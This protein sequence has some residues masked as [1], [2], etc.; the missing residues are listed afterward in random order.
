MKSLMLTGMFVGLFAMAA[1]AEP[2]GLDRFNARQTLQILENQ[3]NLLETNVDDI[4]NAERSFAKRRVDRVIQQLERVS[5]E[6]ARPGALRPGW[7][8]ADGQECVSFCRNLG[9]FNENS[10]DGAQC[11]SGENQV[12]SATGRI[13][14]TYGT[15][16]SVAPTVPARSSGAYCYKPGQKQDND[17][18]DITVGCFCAR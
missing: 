1:F 10:P 3:T 12:G 9:M 5:D 2:H 4:S 14:Y 15:W 17:R 16:G 6:L 8:Q 18:S 7:F 11:T 13:V